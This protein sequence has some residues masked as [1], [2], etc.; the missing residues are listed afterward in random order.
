MGEMTDEELF[1]RFRRGDLA[2]FRE[3]YTRYR[4]SLYLY[5]LRS[6][7][8]QEDAEDLYQEAWSRV[9]H[10]KAGFDGGSFKAW[11]FR[12]A[13]NLQIDRFRRQRLY[14]VGE[15][16]E[17]PEPADPGPQPDRITQADDCA[18]RLKHELGR[19]P[20]EQRDVF[21]LKEESGLS[22]EQIAAMLELGRETIKS[23]LRYALKRLRQMLED[24]L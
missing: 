17:T 22:L 9:M 4:Q 2:S 8:V 12:I 5:L 23:R 6:S 16:S 24:C 18:E 14:L 11:L 19:L 3:L 20:P 1:K 21:L 7:P 10:A 13:R 15:S